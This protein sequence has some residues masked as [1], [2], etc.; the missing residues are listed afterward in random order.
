MA[1]GPYKHPVPY[2]EGSAFAIVGGTPQLALQQDGA[3]GTYY[4]ARDPQGMVVRLMARVALDAEV[5]P[6]N[7][8]DPEEAG[9]VAEEG[10]D[11]EDDP[12]AEGDEDAP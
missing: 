6:T 7:D 2:I 8:P 3:A 9:E 12:A 11:Y 5:S 4:I 10:T 1:Y